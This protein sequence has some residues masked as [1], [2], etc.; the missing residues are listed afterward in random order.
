[1]GAVT[2]TLGGLGGTPCWQ[3]KARS[4]V[5]RPDLGL[6]GVFQGEVGHWAASWVGRRQVCSEFM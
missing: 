1:M 6:R 5:R 3:D 2:S 4:P